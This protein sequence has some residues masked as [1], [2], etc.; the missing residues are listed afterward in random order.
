MEA[1]IIEPYLFIG[2]SKGA[3]RRFA[4]AIIRVL[5]PGWRQP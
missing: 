5:P 2:P 4:E 3:A 1:E